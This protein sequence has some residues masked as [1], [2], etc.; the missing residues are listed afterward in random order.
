MRTTLIPFNGYEDSVIGLNRNQMKMYN[1]PNL[2]ENLRHLPK[3][4]IIAL[5][6]LTRSL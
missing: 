1:D 4:V 2:L 6:M 5:N 3:S